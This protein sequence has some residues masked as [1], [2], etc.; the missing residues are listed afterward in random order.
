M[1]SL[2]AN[3][4]VGTDTEREFLIGIHG[5]K[6]KEECKQTEK[7]REYDLLD[8]PQLY[9][10]SFIIILLFCLFFILLVYFVRISFFWGIIFMH[11]GYFFVAVEEFVTEE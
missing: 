5:C 2:I 11:V 3:N 1:R 8:G 4:L 7:T 6:M 9:G 10:F